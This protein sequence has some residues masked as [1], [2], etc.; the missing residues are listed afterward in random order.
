[1]PSAAPIAKFGFLTTIEITTAVLVDT[2][3][4]YLADRGTKKPFV[5]ITS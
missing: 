5:L 2:P 3:V 4:A 1:M